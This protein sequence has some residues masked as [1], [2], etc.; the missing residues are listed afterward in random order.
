MNR[1]FIILI[2]FLATGLSCLQINEFYPFNSEA[3]DNILFKNDDEFVGPITIS[4]TFPFFQKSYS[5]LFLNTNGLISF[6]K[7]VRDYIPNQFPLENVTGLSP[8]WTDIDTRRGGDIYYR[9]ILDVN[10]LSIIARDIRRAFNIFPN[11]RPTWAFV[12][13]WYQVSAFESYFPFMNNTFQVVIATNGLHS[14]TIFNYEKLT[15]PN[16]N[17]FK[18]VQA[19]FNAGDG[20]NFYALNE[21]FTDAV[22]NIS[23]ISNVG[24]KGKWIFRVDSAN[25]TLGGCSTSGY[26]TVNPNIVYYVGGVSITLSGIKFK[27]FSFK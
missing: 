3:L 9:E 8:Y 21:S 25:I 23:E 7:S 13:T 14:F 5:S 18:R 16:Q 10:Q 24:I 15:W 6:E 26:L 17:I 2:I 1:K 22:V 12:A 11:F 27:C 20:V 19:G 4:T